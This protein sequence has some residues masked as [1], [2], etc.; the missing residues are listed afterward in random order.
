M[1]KHKHTHSSAHTLP[2]SL[3]LSQGPISGPRLSAKAC[4]RG[5]IGSPRGCE[6]PQGS[7]RIITLFISPSLKHPC[8]H[9]STICS[10]RAE[11]SFSFSPSLPAL[12]FPRYTSASRTANKGGTLQYANTSLTQVRW[13]NWTR[14]DKHMHDLHVQ[15][16]QSMEFTCN[17]WSLYERDN[18]V[19][20]CAL[21]GN[22]KAES[23]QY[24]L[25]KICIYVALCR[26]SS[27]SVRRISYET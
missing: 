1:P 15:M 6:R 13:P 12:L 5:P 24:M 22:G 3:V 9:I 19:C 27:F 23:S 8:I 18:F 16:N 17:L 10:E 25:I 4:V 11:R 7:R 20:V 2:F 14:S 26:L 21:L